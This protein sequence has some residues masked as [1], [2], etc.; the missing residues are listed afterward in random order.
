MS[1][2]P[3][4]FRDAVRLNCPTGQSAATLR[5]FRSAVEQASGGVLH[6]HLRETPLRFTFTEWDYP[7][8]FALWAANAL[9]SRPLAER[10]AM[11]DPFHERDLEVLRERVL[12]T[13]EAT[14]EEGGTTFPVPEGQ[15]FHFSASA[16]IEFDLGVAA[17]SLPEMT[18]L[19][20]E[21]PASS[22]YY[23]LYSAR[24]RNPDGFD[25]LSRWLADNGSQ[26]QA[27]H[28]RD[29]DIYMLSLESCRRVVLELLEEVA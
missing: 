15:E 23:H 1:V 2:A 9:E 17:R 6:H 14:L 4:S 18:R 8:D 28:L 21:V 29:L 5:E 19:L 20:G 13:I 10:L 16:L 7:N 27:E 24:L 25:D 22:L 12:E 11:L 26:V 3:F